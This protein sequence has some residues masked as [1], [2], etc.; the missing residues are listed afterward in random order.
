[1]YSGLPPLVM[2]DYRIC[3]S[4]QGKTGVCLVLRISENGFYLIVRDVSL[5]FQSTNTE[6]L[7]I[8]ILALE[9]GTFADGVCPR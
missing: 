8:D 4:F 7:G 9:E 5:A 1:M 2:G 6:K 3:A